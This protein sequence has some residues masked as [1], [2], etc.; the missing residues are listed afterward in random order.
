MNPQFEFSRTWPANPIEIRARYYEVILCMGLFMDS[1]FM[2]RTGI[3]QPSQQ[4]WDQIKLYALENR[5]LNNLFV[6]DEAEP[7]RTSHLDPRLKYPVTQ[8]FEQLAN[9]DGYLY[10]IKHLHQSVP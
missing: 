3:G 5:M 6:R 1:P 7:G 10:H 4:E 2:A 9:W 8:A